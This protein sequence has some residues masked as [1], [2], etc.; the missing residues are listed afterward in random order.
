MTLPG[1]FKLVI[2]LV[3]KQY[4]QFSAFPLGP[5]GQ[6]LKSNESLLTVVC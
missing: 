1:A 6:R 2:S 3:E 5:L 4:F